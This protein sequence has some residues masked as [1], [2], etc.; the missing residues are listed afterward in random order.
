MVDHMLGVMD[1]IPLAGLFLVVSLGVMALELAALIA[2]LSARR[3]ARAGQGGLALARF[4]RAAGLGILAIPIVAGISLHAAR[5]MLIAALTATDP[6]KRAGV[7]VAI[8]AQLNLI[9]LAGDLVTLAVLLW[10][11]ALMLARSAS[12]GTVARSVALVGLGLVPLRLGIER[13]GNRLVHAFAAVAG[14]D[15]DRKVAILGE[16]LDASRR[17]LESFAQIS[18]WAIAGLGVLASALILLDRRPDDPSARSGRGEMLVAGL[19]V[20]LAAA[21]HFGSRPL[22]AEND[23]ARPAP[24]PAQ[25]R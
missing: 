17:Q 18:P 6:A 25:P 9:P 20:V 4:S 22:R 10:L 11:A 13:W 2:G 8:D 23:L 24:P 1:E 14:V 3:R 19:A 12:G 7:G 21:L 16:S 5:S 15:H